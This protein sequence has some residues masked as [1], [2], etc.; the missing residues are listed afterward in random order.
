MRAKSMA[1]VI[2]AGWLFL[3]AS[4][5]SSNPPGDVTPT[6]SVQVA[7]AEVKP[8][9]N[10]VTADAVLYPRDRAAITPKI[11]APVEKFYVDRG[12]RVHAGQLLAE[13]E[14]QDL[15]GAVTENRGGY[16]QAEADYQATLQKAQQGL[17]L[18]KD[19]LESQQKVYDSRENLYKQG[20][21]SAKDVDDARIALTQARD[22]YDLAQKQYDPKSAEG[23]LAVAKGRASSAEAQLSYTKIV[24]PIDGVVTD[25]PF[26]A[27][28]MPPSGSPILTVMDLSQVIARAHVSADQVGQMKAGDAAT[29]SVAGLADAIPAKVTLV[30]PALDPNSTT[31]E[32]WVQAAN[33]GGR[34]KPGVSVQVGIVT[35]TVSHAVVI[36]AAAV[37]TA[38]DGTQSVIVLDADGKPRKQ[39]VTAGIHSGDDVQITQGLKGGEK[40]V[41]TG[42]FE[43][44]N[45]DEDVLAK[46][47]IQVQEAPTPGDDGKAH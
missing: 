7:T 38:S 24:S 19:Q 22:Q 16:A 1:P 27:G 10:V 12:S 2:L 25:R 20:A 40:I 34:L 13:L 31:V 5:C 21:V 23:Q 30:S 26:Y 8:I 11:S 39:A 28:E 35:S 47:K 36:P 17:K 42:A 33:P 14:N 18:A 9:E 4:G 43:L 41:T 29:I 3:L 6:V 46:T 45:E 32:V 37:L 15:R 44:D